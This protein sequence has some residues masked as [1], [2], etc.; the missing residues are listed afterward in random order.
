M[1]GSVFVCTELSGEHDRYINRFAEAHGISR[2][3]LDRDFSV[4]TVTDPLSK[5]RAITKIKKHLN[6]VGSVDL[7]VV[8]N[9]GDIVKTRSNS[10]VSHALMNLESL[11]CAI[12]VIHTEMR[13]KLGVFSGGQ[14]NA[15]IPS[16]IVRVTKDDDERNGAVLTCT[17]SRDTD[18]NHVV[19][20]Q[21]L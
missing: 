4:L 8:S 18:G 6:K 3:E 9:Y 19:M 7:L 13:S 16:F 14:N 17:K 12:S 2:S 5:T 11:G 20:Q 1:G 21:L 10:S 15:D